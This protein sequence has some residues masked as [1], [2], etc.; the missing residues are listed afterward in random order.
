MHGLINRS[1]QSFVRDTYGHAVWDGIA[2]DANL[3]FKCF[4]ALTVY[5]DKITFDVISAASHRLGK[6]RDIFL[7]DLGTY[8][9][10]HPNLEA[11]RRLLRFGGETFVDF[12]WSLDDLA[13]RARLAVPELDLPCMELFEH[14]SDGLTLRC[15][16]G[17]SGYGHVMVGVL[18][19]MS[20]DYGT[21]ALLSYMGSDGGDELISI[22]LLEAD[23]AKGRTFE[24]SPRAV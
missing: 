21:L 9:C 22:Q 11:V 12:L 6:P 18:R 7:E 20:D 1:I 3:G 19:A 4:E 15:C 17:R 10:T 13:D 16:S 2:V 14:K 23:F 8:L 5:D 24:L